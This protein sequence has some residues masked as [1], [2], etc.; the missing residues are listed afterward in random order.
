[1]F[2]LKGSV[3]THV[4]ILVSCSHALPYI[5]S[6]SRGRSVSSQIHLKTKPANADQETWVS[7]QIS[8][9]LCYHMT[10]SPMQR[11]KRLENTPSSSSMILGLR[12]PTVKPHPGSTPGNSLT[13]LCVQVL[14]LWLL[15]HTGKAVFSTPPPLPCGFRPEEWGNDHTS[16]LYLFQPLFWEAVGRSNP[17]LSCI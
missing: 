11:R 7:T 6:S 2:L 5:R 17:W 1:M 8:K 12:M 9:L 13:Q 3:P 16:F 4:F 14:I 15:D 10:A